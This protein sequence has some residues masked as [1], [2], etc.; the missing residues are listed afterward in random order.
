MGVVRTIL[1]GDA[2]YYYYKP[3]Y[4]NYVADK[5]RYYRISSEK[6]NKKY[7]DLKNHFLKRYDSVLDYLK[8]IQIQ[9]I[10]TT[11][12]FKVAMAGLPILPPWMGLK[13][14][15]VKSDLDVSMR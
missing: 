4:L 3:E 9:F 13:A 2:L 7:T 5:Y 6:N 10:N 1:S 14:G 12:I 11:I 8:L 15:N